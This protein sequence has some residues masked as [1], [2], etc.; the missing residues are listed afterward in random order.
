MVRAMM[1]KTTRKY[2]WVLAANAL[3]ILAVIALWQFR[4]HAP[5]LKEGGDGRYLPQA[6]YMAGLTEGADLRDLKGQWTL[7]NLWA[8]WCPPCL[9]E[10]P[11]LETLSKEYKSKGLQVIAISLDE[12][13][14]PDE[15]KA[16]ADKHKFGAV[17]RNWDDKGQV[18]ARLNPAGLPTTYLA[19][20]S[21]KIVHVFEGERDWSS[22]ET[23]AEID[24]FMNQSLDVSSGTS[25]NR[26]P[27]RP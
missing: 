1:K 5:T 11:G 9:L 3:L 23:R 13:S 8:T 2:I 18:Y 26:S 19:D 22:P 14:S 10:M 24:R 17:A 20:P 4:L 7:L 27:A 12:A 16:K 25:V 21:G 15:I 6:A